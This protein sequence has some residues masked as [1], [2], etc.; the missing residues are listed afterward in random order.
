MRVVWASHSAGTMGAEQAMIEGVATLREAGVEIHV[1]LP[2]GQEVAAAWKNLGVP[3]SQIPLPWWMSRR[4]R[5]IPR[6]WVRLLYRLPAARSA[7]RALFAEV[8]P[9]VVV[10]NTSVIPLAALAAKA[11]GIR[12]VWYIHEY[13]ARGLGF[14]YDFGRALSLKLIDRLSDMVVVNAR[15]VRAHFAGPIAPDRIRLIYYLMETPPL[16]PAGPESRDFR[17]VIVGSLS[18]KKRQ[19]DA[20]RAVGLL[21]GKGVEVRLAVVG[22]G[23]PEIQ[24]YL[25]GLADELGVGAAVD[26]TGPTDDPFASFAAADVAL[27]CSEDE[28]FGRVTVEAMKM[29][30]TVIGAD[31]G[32]TAELI[33]DGY[34]GLLYK[35][36]DIADLAGKIER[37]ARDPDLVRQMSGNAYAWA[38]ETF[39]REKYAAG[40]L[41][42]F[43]EALAES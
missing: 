6:S 43:R 3:Y 31:S 38:H 27:I 14:F 9:D 17:L 25:A 1:V 15:G 10:T 28:A 16:P 36:R 8:R 24:R 26:F 21:A 41:G 18:R 30:T 34:N 37:L 20:I 29:G 7:F 13:G 39:N 2:A 33:T 32:G 22:P 19:E 11:A 35:P 4:K 42:V 23:G 12:H 40:L 5:D